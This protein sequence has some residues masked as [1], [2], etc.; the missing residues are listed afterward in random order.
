MLAD[1]I[2]SIVAD[3][4]EALEGIVKEEL[5]SKRAS[6]LARCMDHLDAYLG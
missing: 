4:E 2:E 1:E 5:L 3:D 6:L